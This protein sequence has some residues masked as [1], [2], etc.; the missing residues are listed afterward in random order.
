MSPSVFRIIYTVYKAPNQIICIV[1]VLMYIPCISQTLTVVF[2]LKRRSFW[3]CWKFVWS[4]CNRLRKRLY[5]RWRL[6][7]YT[8]LN[9]SFPHIRIRRHCSILTFIKV[10]VRC[11]QASITGNALGRKSFSK[12]ISERSKSNRLLDGHCWKTI[13]CHVFIT[14]RRGRGNFF[15]QFMELFF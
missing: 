6:F 3:M 8:V 13:V 7:F 10:F 5:V 2:C 15:I 12:W 9:T 11:N 1:R 4:M 14:V